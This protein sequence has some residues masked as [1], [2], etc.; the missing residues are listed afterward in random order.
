MRYSAP[1][2]KRGRSPGHGH[3]MH[4]DGQQ[5][6]VMQLSELIPRLPYNGLGVI[7]GGGGVNFLSLSASLFLSF[8]T[9]KRFGSSTISRIGTGGTFL[10]AGA[11]ARMIGANP[12][13]AG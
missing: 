6:S 4:Q 9:S 12:P 3:G 10:S 13:D 7:C 2:Q 8:S 1:S 11:W 5:P